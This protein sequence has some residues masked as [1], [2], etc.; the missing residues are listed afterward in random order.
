MPSS[1]ITAAEAASAAF[2]DWSV[3]GPNARRSL[4]NAA[5][6]E[7]DAR[8]DAFVQTMAEELRASEPWARFTALCSAARADMR[9]NT[10]V[11]IC[12]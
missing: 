9:S 3:L 8:T 5:A 10:L 12:S 11:F 4:L 2:P 6:G 1:P 7:L